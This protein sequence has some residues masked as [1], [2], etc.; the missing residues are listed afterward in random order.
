[1]TEQQSLEHFPS[2]WMVWEAGPSAAGVLRFLKQSVTAVPFP[3][4]SIYPLPAVQH[5]NNAYEACHNVRGDSLG[6]CPGKPRTW[7]LCP[8]LPYRL[9]GSDWTRSSQ[10]THVARAGAQG[11]DGSCVLSSVRCHVTPDAHIAC[12]GVDAV[13]GSSR[14][15]GTATANKPPDALRMPWNTNCWLWGWISQHL[16]SVVALGKER[17]KKHDMPP[18][19]EFSQRCGATTHTQAH[20][21]ST[22]L[23][24][25][26][27]KFYISSSMQMGRGDGK[28]GQHAVLVR[29]RDAKPAAVVSS[30]ETD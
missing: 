18:N 9:D 19:R 29:C 4:S 6:L 21:H 3:F 23:P 22:P 15:G 14:S 17:E 5:T 10:A 7:R 8:P 27:A 1:M 2:A 25:N 11:S 26:L 24:L 16:I 20:R 13:T 28:Q 12:F 30:C